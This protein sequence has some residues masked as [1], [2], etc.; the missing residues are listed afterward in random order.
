M[1]DH[2][3]LE[4][5]SGARVCSFKSRCN[6]L[7]HSTVVCHATHTKFD[8]EFFCKGLGN[9]NIEKNQDYLKSVP[10]ERGQSE[11]IH[12]LASLILIL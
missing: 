8:F 5:Q 4:I 1:G 10:R 3:C 2:F 6:L 7:I 9:Y 12:A 11:T